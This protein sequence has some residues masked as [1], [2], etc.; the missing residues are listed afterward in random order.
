MSSIKSTVDKKVEDVIAI[1]SQDFDSTQKFTDVFRRVD[2]TYKDLVKRGLIQPKGY[3]LM[4]ADNRNY[5]RTISINTYN[6]DI[7]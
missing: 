2:K 5:K 4:T 6:A 7:K 3:K 1:K